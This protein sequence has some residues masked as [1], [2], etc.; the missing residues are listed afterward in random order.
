M[1]AN[2]KRMWQPKYKAS[3]K[4]VDRHLTDSEKAEWEKHPSTKNLFVF[5]PIPEPKKEIPA[6][7][8]EF[9]PKIKSSKKNS[10]G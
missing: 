8:K 3:G 5:L 1:D 4:L 6:E 10:N 7:L 9:V 2:R